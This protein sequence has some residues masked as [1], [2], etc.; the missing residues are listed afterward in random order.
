MC[1]PPLLYGDRVSEPEVLHGRL[2]ERDT[3]VGVHGLVEGRQEVADAAHAPFG[4]VDNEVVAT[5]RHDSEQHGEE[6]PC[7][8]Q[9]PATMTQQSG[10]H[11]AGRRSTSVSSS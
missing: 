10:D 3:Q 9:F 2:G 7:A 1:P 4:G 11:G 8:Q 5:R 6:W